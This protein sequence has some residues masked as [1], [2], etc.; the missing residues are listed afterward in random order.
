VGD[1]TG[2]MLQWY[3]CNKVEW[4]SGRLRKFAQPTKVFSPECTL[5]FMGYKSSKLELYMVDHVEDF[6]GEEGELPEAATA[7]YCNF[8]NSSYVKSAVL[9]FLSAMSKYQDLASLDDEHVNTDIFSTMTFRTSCQDGVTEVK[10]HYIE[11]L[12]GLLRH[13]FAVCH[14]ISWIKRLDY[15]LLESFQDDLF[16]RRMKKVK[17]IQ[18]IGMNLGACWDRTEGTEMRWFYEHYEKRYVGFDRML[19]WEGRKH[20]RDQNFSFDPKYTSSFQYLNISADLNLNADGN[21]LRVLHKTARVEDFVMVKLDIDQPLEMNIILALLESP[22]AL[23]IID[24]FFIEHHTENPVMWPY[25]KSHVACKLGDTYEIFLRL[26]NSG[27]RAHG[28]P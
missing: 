8:M 10:N 7:R 12:I 27:V 11:P 13:P 21:P 28:W 22:N 19:M 20:D 18:F 17:Q 5:E 24:E 14:D 3:K 1:N 4:D 26:R 2:T 15:L 25:W 9:E 23:A 6:K 16:Y